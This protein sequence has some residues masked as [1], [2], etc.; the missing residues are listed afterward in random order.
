MLQ[1]IVVGL[2][3]SRESVAAADW[4]AEEAL[5]RGL[6]LRLVH[7]WEGSPEPAESTALP[8]LRV[9]QSLVIG[10]EAPHPTTGATWDASHT[11]RST[12]SGAPSPSSHTTDRIPAR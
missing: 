5:R 6:P 12:T 4:A 7:A 10:R 3:G 1:P 11:R 9:P 8:E 2:D